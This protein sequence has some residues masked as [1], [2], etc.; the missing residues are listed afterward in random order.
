MVMLFDSRVH[1]VARI[2]VFGTESV[3]DDLVK[4]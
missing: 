1:D 4:Y 2:L 3:L